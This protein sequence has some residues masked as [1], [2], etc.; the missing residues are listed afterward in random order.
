MKEVMINIPGMQSAHCQNRVANAVKEIETVQIQKLAAGQLTVSYADD[1]RQ[2]EIVQ[3][4]EKAGYAV[5][6]ATKA[7]KAVCSTGCCNK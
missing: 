2:E 3:A 5:D 7:N 6:S 4:I 1:I